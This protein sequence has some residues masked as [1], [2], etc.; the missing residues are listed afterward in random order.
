MVV[1]V[2]LFI[3]KMDLAVVAQVHFQ[4]QIWKKWTWLNIILFLIFMD[5]SRTLWNVIHTT[6]FVKK[7]YSACSKNSNPISKLIRRGSLK[8]TLR[9][10]VQVGIKPKAVPDGLD[11]DI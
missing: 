2:E 8:A 9:K 7:F 11:F 3:Q 10:P 4:I 5:Q 1:Q 6:L